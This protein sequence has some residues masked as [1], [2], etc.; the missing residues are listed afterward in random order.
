MLRAASQH[1]AVQHLGLHKF[2]LQRYALQ[3]VVLQSCL[4]TSYL[5]FR[6]ATLRNTSTSSQSGGLVGGR[7]K[8]SHR[9]SS[10]G[11]RH[12]ELGR[13]NRTCLTAEITTRSKPRSKQ[14]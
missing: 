6:L 7:A 2:A 5:A 8:N 9:L 14:A 4:A 13:V 11:A 1:G 10:V 3:H 12:K